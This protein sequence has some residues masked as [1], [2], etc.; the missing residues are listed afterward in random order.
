MVAYLYN[1]KE[2]FDGLELGNCSHVLGHYCVV[3]I[4]W[5]N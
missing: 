1:V 3:L 4:M 5:K 2:E